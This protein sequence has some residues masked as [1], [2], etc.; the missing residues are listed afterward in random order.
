MFI[1]NT[2]LRV[3]E[4][5]TKDLSVK[6]RKH[7]PCFSVQR[8]AAVPTAS[9]STFAPFHSQGGSQGPR[10]IHHWVQVIQKI[11][12]ETAMHPKLLICVGV[13]FSKRPHLP[14]SLN[15]FLLVSFSSKISVH[16]ACVLFN[17]PNY[18]DS[19]CFSSAHI[20]SSQTQRIE[21]TVS[22]EGYRDF[23]PGFAFQSPI[24]LGC[25]PVTFMDLSF[26]I[27]KLD[28]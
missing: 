4:P 19:I 18:S 8:P 12:L 16:C 13:I 10:I 15:N 21:N 23:R 28:G 2:L 11:S 20:L 7:F 14:C 25:T 17:S 24:W 27:L 6:D 9:P 3:W 22:W 1:K 5:C 26:L